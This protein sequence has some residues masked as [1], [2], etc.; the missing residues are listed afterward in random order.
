MPFSRVKSNREM[1]TLVN[2]YSTD[3][4]LQYV[5]KV[6]CLCKLIF[7]IF[8]SFPHALPLKRSR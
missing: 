7:D 5:T 4:L 1:A 3:A 2:I 6:F 8:N